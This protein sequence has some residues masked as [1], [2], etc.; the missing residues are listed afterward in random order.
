MLLWIWPRNDGTGLLDEEFRDGDVFQVK[1]DS[2]EPSIG[3]QERKSWLIVKIP[4]PPNKVRVMEDLG[5]S[6]YAQGPAGSEPIVRRARIYAVNWR[7][8]FTLEQQ[9]IVADPTQMLA[10]AT[11]DGTVAGGV[12]SDLFTLADVF[13][14]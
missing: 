6:E 12:V 3:T 2:F 5:R 8:K 1:D 7:T 10:D 13:R 9:A 4:D 14:K 11:A